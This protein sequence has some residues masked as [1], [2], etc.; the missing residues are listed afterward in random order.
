MGNVKSF[1]TTVALAG[2][3]GAA[4]A[5]DAPAPAARNST[6]PLNLPETLNVYGKPI[7][8][9]VKASAIVNGEVITQT[10]IDQRMQL[11][12]IAN[13][14]PIPETEQERLRVQVLRNLIDETLQIQAAKQADISVSSADIDKTVARVA[15]GV[16]RTPA[17]LA[18][19][20]KA[21][22]SSIRSIRR[23]I[24]GE[25]AWSRLQRQKI[26]SQVSVGEEEVKAVIDR[27]NASKGAQE[28][29]VGE[30]FLAATPANQAEVAANAQKIV[31]ALRQGAS[32]AGYARQ[33]SEASTAAVGGDLGWVR[34]EQLPDQLANTIRSMAPGQLSQPIALPGGYSIVAVQDSRKILTADPRNAVLSLKQVSISF[35]KGTTAAAADPTLQ[36]FAAAAQNIGGC[37][38]AE[39]VAAEFKGDVVQSDQVKLRDLPPALQQMMMPMQV[40]QATRPFGSIDDGVRVLVICGRDE[41]QGGNA[42]NP[43]AVY[44]QLQEERVNMRA[45]RYLRDLRRDAIIDYR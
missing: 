33:Y 43:D 15:E 34:P 12:A 41:D 20:L 6:A 32:F 8:A 31:E 5:Q 14:Q 7:P 9:V 30:I 19:Y 37:G 45:R 29:R 28:Y 40:G 4:L 10:D 38:G 18:D 42:P 13:N 1:L 36:K 22:G 39:K 3:A 44:A 21:N 26:E 23:Q 27:L 24:E 25:I 17:Q 11:L 16:K 35:P 2:L